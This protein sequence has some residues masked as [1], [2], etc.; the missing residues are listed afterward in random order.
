LLAVFVSVAFVVVPVVVCSGGGQLVGS[1]KVRPLAGVV[2]WN[3]ASA[4]V[5]DDDD[6]AAVVVVVV[7]SAKV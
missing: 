2:S 6:D 3:D 4:A 5:V 1:A 7:G